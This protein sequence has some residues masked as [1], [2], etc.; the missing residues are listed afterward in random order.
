VGARVAKYPWWS[1]SSSTF[2][3]HRHDLI[4]TLALFNECFVLVVIEL[5]LIKEFNE[6]HELLFT[7]L[8]TFI[9]CDEYVHVL[10][11]A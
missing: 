1:I 8:S 7:D 6:D 4:D 3:K 9:L 11:G 5:T 2:S 10:I